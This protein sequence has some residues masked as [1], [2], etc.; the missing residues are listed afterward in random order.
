[1]N[2]TAGTEFSALSP[3][4]RRYWKQLVPSI[5]TEDTFVPL[6]PRGTNRES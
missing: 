6:A 1:M 3:L 5:L 2:V 4:V